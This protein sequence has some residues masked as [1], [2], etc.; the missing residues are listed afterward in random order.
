MSDIISHVGDDDFKEQVL[1]SDIPVLVDFW[2]PWCGP[3][4]ALGP[5]LE[6]LAGEYDG[7]VKFCKVNTDDNK[8]YATEFGIR[9]IPTVMIFQ[10]GE[11][12]DTTV[13]MLPKN[14][15]KEKI[16]QYL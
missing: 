10:N 2:A 4:R 7:K 15:L 11:L 13:G 14:S 12:K 16:D 3:C 9:G 5:I 6:D 1:D 8:K